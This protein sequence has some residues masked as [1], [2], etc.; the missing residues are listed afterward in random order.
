MKSSDS[1]FLFFM[2][3]FRKKRYKRKIGF[4]TAARILFYL[5]KT[6]VYIYEHIIIL[7]SVCVR[8]I[9]LFDIGGFF[10]FQVFILLLHWANGKYF[11]WIKIL[12]TNVAHLFSVFCEAVYFNWF[13]ECILFWKTSVPNKWWQHTYALLLSWLKY[14]IILNFF[15]YH[16]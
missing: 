10:I 14:Q 2:N 12:L 1:L 8:R 13:S 4:P 7:V 9:P 5:N 16:Y 11:S 3:L 6:L 15:K